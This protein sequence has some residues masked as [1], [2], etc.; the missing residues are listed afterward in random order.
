MA[1]KDPSV[2]NGD[3]QKFFNT[4]FRYPKPSDLREKLELFNA[5]NIEKFVSDY[6][7]KE[8]TVGDLFA[9]IPYND[10]TT[11]SATNLA[12]AFMGRQDIVKIWVSYFLSKEQFEEY[13][14]LEPQIYGQYTPVGTEPAE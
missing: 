3:I 1:R 8:F 9:N 6:A 13:K 11:C 12:G 4:G 5:C 14:K 10:R 7:G 2:P